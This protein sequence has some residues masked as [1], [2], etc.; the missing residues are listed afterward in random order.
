MQQIYGAC[1][2][3]VALSLT[4]SAFVETDRSSI[5][6]Q[7]VDEIP[8]FPFRTFTDLSI[9]LSEERWSLGIDS[10]AASY[11]ASRHDVWWKR[12]LVKALSLTLVA[13]AMLTVIGA[14]DLKEYWAIVGVPAMALTFYLAAPSLPGRRILTVVGVGMFIGFI[15][16]LVVPNDV[17]ARD[18]QLPQTQFYE[19]KSYST[20]APCGPVLLLLAPGHPSR[21]RWMASSKA[22]SRK[23]MLLPTSAAP[24]RSARKT[25]WAAW[26]ASL[27]SPAPLAEP[28][29]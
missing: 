4:M 24:S 10:F 12:S 29:V 18:V 6:W 13:V 8:Q 5:R 15:A 14:L 16:G 28:F 3:N 27:A 21:A 2:G 20:F 11:W 22:I 25:I 9:A 26:K 1:E 17:S 23:S 19:A 7:R